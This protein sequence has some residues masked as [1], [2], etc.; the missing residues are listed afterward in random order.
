MNRNERLRR[1]EKSFQPVFQAPEFHICFVSS[2]SDDQRKVT[3]S[4]ILHPGGTQIWNPQV[5]SVK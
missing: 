1:L 5:L 4:L 2:I 3:A